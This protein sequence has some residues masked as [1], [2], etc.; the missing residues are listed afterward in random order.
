VFKVGP[1]TANLVIPAYRFESE[2]ALLL[3][4]DA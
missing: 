2:N 3:G 1:A 4:V